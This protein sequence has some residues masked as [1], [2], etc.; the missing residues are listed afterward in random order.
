MRFKQPDF[1]FLQ[2]RIWRRGDLLLDR[3]I[4]GGQLRRNM[5]SLRPRGGFAG[6]R[7]PRQSLGYIRYADEQHFGDFTDRST[8]IGGG[9]NTLS[10][11]L[12]VRLASPPKHRRL[13]IKP[14]G[15]VRIMDQ[16][17]FARPRFQSGLKC[18]NAAFVAAMEDVLEVYTR[19]RD[20]NRPLVCL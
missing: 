2:R 8:N 4:Q 12:P 13:P 1:Q 6:S 19:P 7:A 10:Q 17:G 16:Q 20:P 11:I 9:E 18:S 15:N 14:L 5:A 3:P